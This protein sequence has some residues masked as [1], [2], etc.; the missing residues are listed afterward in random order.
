MR[1]LLGLI[2]L[3]GLSAAQEPHS[4][5]LIRGVLLE[6]D[7]GAGSGEFSVR[8]ANSQVFR[9]SFNEKT[10]VERERRMID[11]ERLEP[12]EQVEV[13]SDRDPGAPLRHA[14]TIRVLSSPAAPRRLASS[15]R[16]RASTGSADRRVLTADLS[17]SGV[18]TDVSGDRIVLRTPQRTDQ[19]ILLR[20]DTR[21]VEDGSMVPSAAL[22]PNT[23][24][25]V[26]A[27]RTVYGEVEAYQVAWG[28][29]LQPA[30]R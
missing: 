4:G 23:R 15:G 14:L 17:F 24:V 19:R 2:V 25:F 6:R 28:R 20:Q 26:R 8:D 21:Y 18:V 13:V 29:I 22:T 5:P 27:S 12:G 1:V 11:V 3:A 16:Y 7:T 10:Y 30:S 9:F